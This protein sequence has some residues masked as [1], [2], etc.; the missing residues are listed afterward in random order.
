LVSDDRG[1]SYGVVEG[2]V[3]LTPV[4]EDIGDDTVNEL[5]R[6]YRDAS[7]EH[8]DWTEYREVMVSD[9]RLVARLV[10]EHAYGQVR[11]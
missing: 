5:V 4:A 2:H 9:R 10:V 3:E 6:L 11:S 8:P 1:W 7:G